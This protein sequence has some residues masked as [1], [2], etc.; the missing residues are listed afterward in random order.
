MNTTSATKNPQQMIE[1]QI[2]PQRTIQHFDGRGHKVPT[3]LAHTLG[4]VRVCRSDMV[5]IC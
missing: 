5:V 3:I 4:D 1:T 2:L